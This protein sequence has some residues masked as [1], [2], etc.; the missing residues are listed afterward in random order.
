MYEFDVVIIE[1]ETGGYVALVPALPGCHTQGDTL[2][3]LMENVKEAIELYLETLTDEEKE[4]LLRQK[5]IGIQKVRAL[6]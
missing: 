4:E 3:E 5:V 2:E 6:A 1:D